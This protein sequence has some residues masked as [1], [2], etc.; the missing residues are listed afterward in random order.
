[1][2][3]F[4][5]SIEERDKPWL[6]G[7]PIVVGADP[8]GGAGRGV[9]STANYKARAYGIR[10]ALPIKK[11]WEYAE[12]A[13]KRGKRAVAFLTPSS[14]TYTT[15][16]AS[17]MAIINRFVSIVEVVSIDEAYIDLS[18]CHSFEQAKALA[19]KLKQL[20]KRER[21]LTAS[22]GIGQNR[23]LAK[24]AS[25]H[26][27]PDGLTVVLPSQTSTFLSPLP[28]RVIPGIGPKATAILGR[29]GGQ[30]IGE[31]R[32]LTWEFLTSIL[33]SYGFDIYQKAR[34]ID[35]D[36]VS[37]KIERPLSI[38]EHET[39]AKDTLDRRVIMH[40]VLVMSSRIIKKLMQQ[41]FR[42]FR[43]V[44]LTIR[45]HDFETKS[46]SL[47]AKNILTK[48]SELELR[49]IKLLLPFLESGENPHQKSIRMVGIRIEKLI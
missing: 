43:T 47:T 2:D 27:K 22:I 6:K 35:D 13:K 49:V 30:T 1:M 4:F 10:S 20:I 21:K 36:V 29:N 44:V 15:E 42:G 26:N 12:M 32:K 45:F 3:A 37:K 5:A 23:M 18:F 24:V 25:D 9:V 16:S 28:V 39:F 34:G 40:E 31:L 48:E 46:R 41:K 8:S 19:A 11:A 17:I 7:L 38:G 14:G 33:G